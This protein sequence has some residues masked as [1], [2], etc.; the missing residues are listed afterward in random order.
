MTVDN[1]LEHLRKA[2][3]YLLANRRVMLKPL[4]CEYYCTRQLLIALRNVRRK[5]Q[6]FT[7]SDTLLTDDHRYVLCHTASEYTRNRCAT[8]VHTTETIREWKYIL[9]THPF[10]HSDNSDNSSFSG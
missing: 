4:L 10:Y 6:L 1:Q 2:L 8:C 9:I 5:V 7:N 3:A